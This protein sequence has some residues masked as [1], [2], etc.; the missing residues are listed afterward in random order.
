MLAYKL[1]VIVLLQM[2]KDSDVDYIRIR[3]NCCII[4]NY[5]SCR[6]FKESEEKVKF[7]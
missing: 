6:W 1:G 4:I 3:F 2:E 7:I 5:I